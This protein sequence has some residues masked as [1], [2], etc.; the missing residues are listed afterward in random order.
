[1][2]L[3]SIAIFIW[4]L[5][6]FAFLV[7]IFFGKRLPRQGDWVV[8]GSMFIDLILALYIFANVILTNNPNF[9]MEVHFDW[10]TLGSQNL[11]LSFVLDNVT[12]VMLV[13]VTVVSSLVFLYSTEYMRGDPRYSRYF[14][15][16]SLFA[17]SMLGLVI[18]E[19]LFGIYMCW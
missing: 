14:A 3:L 9:R 7:Q 4:L 19:N 5:P 17:F 18:F 1:M 13:V 10:I 11:P 16:L 2:N 6:L 8:V 15:F 12:A